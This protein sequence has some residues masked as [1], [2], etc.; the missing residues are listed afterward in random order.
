[1]PRNVSHIGFVPSN[2]YE[3]IAVVI[4]KPQKKVLFLVVSPLRGVGGKGLSTKEKR[5][6]FFLK[7][8][9]VLLTIKPRGGG[10]RAL[11]GCPLKQ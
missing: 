4:G 3:I 2:N 5:T 7:F 1:M 8:V 9:I 11:V 10:L 6:L